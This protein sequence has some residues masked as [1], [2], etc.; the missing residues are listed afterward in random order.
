MKIEFVAENDGIRL[1]E[2]LKLH[3]SRKLY[4]HIKGFKAK[5]YVNGVLT[6]TYKT[7]NKG[8]NIVVDYV[9]EF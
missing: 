3:V 1:S 4:K 2:E 8:D 6:E 7:I 5:I 9:K